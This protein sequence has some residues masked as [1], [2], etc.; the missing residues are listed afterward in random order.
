MLLFPN[1]KQYDAADCGAACLKNISRYYG[2]IYSLQTFRELSHVTRE[3]VSLLGVDEAAAAAG[4]ITKRVKINFEY[5]KSEA[6]LP[7]IVH[8]EQNHFVVVYK[9]QKRL[10]VYLRPCNRTRKIFRK[11]IH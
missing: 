5:L 3:G 7:C 11:N 8:W 6:R 9:I 4:F 2:K 1:D 10:G